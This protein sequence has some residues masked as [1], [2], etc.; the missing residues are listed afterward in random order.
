MFIHFLMT[1]TFTAALLYFKAL[2][3]IIQLQTTRRLVGT[4]LAPE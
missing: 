1:R 4:T 2:A 3:I